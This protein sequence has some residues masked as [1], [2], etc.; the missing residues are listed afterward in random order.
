MGDRMDVCAVKEVH[1][2]ED[3]LQKTSIVV[4]ISD[5]AE[6][7][8][9]EDPNKGEVRLIEISNQSLLSYS[10]PFEHKLK[11]DTDGAVMSLGV[12]DDNCIVFSS[13]AHVKVARL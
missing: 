6:E 11:I 12:M 1:T 5:W 9:T 10:S 2:K 13:G 7:D 4:G 3:R 8:M